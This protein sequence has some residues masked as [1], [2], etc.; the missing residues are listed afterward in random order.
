VEATRQQEE[1]KKHDTDG[2]GSYQLTKSLQN[3]KC[4]HQQKHTPSFKPEKPLGHE[5]ERTTNAVISEVE[6][7]QVEW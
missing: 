6:V 5:G 7:C 3:K 1:D 4:H 2:Q